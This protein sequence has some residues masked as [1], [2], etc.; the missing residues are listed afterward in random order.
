MSKL[1]NAA[2]IW[3][4]QLHANQADTIAAIINEISGCLILR[5]RRQFIV[6]HLVAVLPVH[7]KNVV[8]PHKRTMSNSMFAAKAATDLAA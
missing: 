8:L 4:N 1:T 7:S 5:L 6:I 3:P 2:I